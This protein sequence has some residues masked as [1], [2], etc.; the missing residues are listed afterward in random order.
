MT[1]CL[2]NY[3]T[4]VINRIFLI[5]GLVVFIPVYFYNYQLI[6]KA[7]DLNIIVC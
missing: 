4:K 1:H 5:V 2:I 3:P 7:M 6:L